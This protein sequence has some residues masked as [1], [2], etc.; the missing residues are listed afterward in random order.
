MNSR[1][2]KPIFQIPGFKT[3]NQVEVEL[4]PQ[5]HHEIELQCDYT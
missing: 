5:L 4:F 1:M 3:E 2:K